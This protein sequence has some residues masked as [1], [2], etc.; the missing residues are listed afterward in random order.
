MNNITEVFHRSQIRANPGGK[1]VCGVQVLTADGEWQ[2]TGLTLLL[3]TSHPCGSI[4]AEEGIQTNSSFL[5]KQKDKPA[6]GQMRSE[7][8]FLLCLP[9]KNP[10]S[11]ELYQW[12]VPP[13]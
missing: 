2:M 6:L 1:T 13:H 10:E 3:L 4:P 5:L 7:E 9:I 12:N 11:S 8:R